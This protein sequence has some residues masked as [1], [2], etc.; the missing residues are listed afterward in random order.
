MCLLLSVMSS[1]YVL[2]L[3][4]RPV[5]DNVVFVCVSTWITTWLSNS[6]ELSRV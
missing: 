2:G 5:R 3:N 1:P 4:K 6:V